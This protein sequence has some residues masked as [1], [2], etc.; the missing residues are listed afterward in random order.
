[1]SVVRGGRSSPVGTFE[2]CS[3][4][5]SGKRAAPKTGA[6]TAGTSTPA[7]AIKQQWLQ[8][9]QASAPGAAPLLPVPVS[10]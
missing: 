1:M 5:G 2:R 4:A 7:K 3:G 10:L 6:C 8:T 9:L